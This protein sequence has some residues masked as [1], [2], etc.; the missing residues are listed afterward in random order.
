MS[1]LLCAEFANENPVRGLDGNTF[2]MAFAD[3]RQVGWII[4]SEKVN[5]PSRSLPRGAQSQMFCLLCLLV[6]YI[7]LIVLFFAF[8]CWITIQFEYCSKFHVEQPVAMFVICN[9]FLSITSLCCSC[10]F[11]LT[12]SDNLSW[13]VL[14]MW[15]SEKF[16]YNCP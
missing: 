15:V 4:H 16:L 12:M 2:Q 10:V 8:L 7:L 13:V 14:H 6:A 1:I 9:N 3:L 5:T 11:L